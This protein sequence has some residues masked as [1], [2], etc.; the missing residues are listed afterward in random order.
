MKARKEI[1]LMTSQQQSKKSKNKKTNTE[2]NQGEVILNL[3]LHIKHLEDTIREMKQAWEMI[4]DK[5]ED[6]IEQIEKVSNHNYETANKNAEV[7]EQNAKSYYEMTRAY[8][9]LSEFGKLAEELGI[10]T[11]KHNSE[12]PENK[13]K[14]WKFDIG[15]EV[16]ETGKVTS[17]MS[18]KN[19]KA[20]KEVK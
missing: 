3:S 14:G 20:K 2:K 12:L 15:Q 9:A 19:P 1:L 11:K 7:A 18:L 10:D 13:Y 6:H 17:F 4:V 8:N 16:S 5:Y